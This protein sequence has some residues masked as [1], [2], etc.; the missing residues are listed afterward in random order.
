[1]E[2]IMDNKTISTVNRKVHQKY[3]ETKGIKPK[4]KK[5]SLAKGSS[6]NSVSGKNFLFTYHIKAVTSNG[7]SLNKYVRAVVNES[8]KIVKISTSK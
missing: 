2:S 7:K 8:G 4:I 1:M 5:Q 3:P 6:G